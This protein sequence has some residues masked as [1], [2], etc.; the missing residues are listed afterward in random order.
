MPMAMQS[1]TETSTWSPWPVRAG[2]Q[3][4]RR[5]R[6]RR[7]RS[8]PATPPTSPRPR[9]APH[10]GSRGCPSTRRRPGGRTRCAAV[11]PT[12]P[13]RPTSVM[14]TTTWLGPAACAPATSNARAGHDDVG[15]PASVT[16]PRHGDRPLGG[17]QELEE[18]R[19]PVAPLG[20]PPVGLDHHHVGAGVGQQLG[21]VAAGDATG[22]VQ[23]P[24]ALEHHR[25]PATAPAA[26][27]LTARSP[28]AGSR[29]RGGRRSPPSPPVA[30][31]PPRRP[32]RPPRTRGHRGRGRWDGGSRSRT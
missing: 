29:G 17:V 28:R 20:P 21:G 24:D 25:S 8:R 30:P 19:R 6:R 11:R 10:R 32:G 23:H 12:G 2:P 1:S 22:Q 16:L 14:V 5:R 7:R 26:T 13:S 9:G 18:P 3:P 4:R 15:R 27:G 31:P